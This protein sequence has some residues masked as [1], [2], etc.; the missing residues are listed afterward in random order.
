MSKDWRLG[1]NGLTEMKIPNGL[2]I[3]VCSSY[4]VMIHGLGLASS[5]QDPAEASPSGK[6]AQGL[7]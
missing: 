5:P 2:N 1:M 3:R 6:S 4:D 7:Y